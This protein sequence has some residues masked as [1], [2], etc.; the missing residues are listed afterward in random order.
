M[1]LIPVYDILLRPAN[2][3]LITS[4]IRLTSLQASPGIERL[5][6]VNLIAWS[7]L[8]SPRASEDARSFPIAVQ[9]KNNNKKHHMA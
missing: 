1:T 5:N 9:Q 6:D 3:Q 8:F 4:K 2:L 7:Y